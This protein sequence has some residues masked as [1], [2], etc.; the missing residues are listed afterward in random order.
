[1]GIVFTCAV[2]FLHLLVSGRWE[3]VRRLQILPG[4]VV[5]LLIA[6]PWH[7]AAGMA[8][9]GFLWFYFVNEHFLRYLGLRYPKD[10]DTVP[11]ILFWVLH[12]VWV[13]P[14]TAFLWGLWRSFPKMARPTGREDQVNLFLYVWVLT[15]LLFFS[16]S[17]TQ[18][19]YTFPTL[20]A[21]ALLLGRV[22]GR[23]DSP[24]GAADQRKAVMGMSVVAVVGVITAG[25]LFALA[26]MG[27]GGGGTSDLS[28]TLTIN[29]EQYALSF[30]HMHDLT[31]ATFGHL[32]PLV[33]RTAVV[34]LLGPLLALAAGCLRQWK[35]T[36]FFLA[37]MM[38]G[39][40]HSYRCG[41]E[42]FEPIMSSK[43]LAKT[44]EYHYRPGDRL[45]VNGVYERGSSIN[46]YTGIQLSLLN[47]HF[48]NLWYG[49][50][51]PDSPP[52]FFNDE[53]FLGIW[54]SGARV[55]LFSEKQPLADFEARHPGFSGGARTLA[56]DGGKTVLANW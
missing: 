44:I 25:C 46:Y 42:A 43:G 11:V 15:I 24:E 5:F 35:L 38:A 56:R 19:Y 27:K 10:Y 18:E 17:T 37:V 23:L 12:L 3:A 21:F 47:G 8:N 52:I 33:F 26:W 45:V 6:A 49:S 54:N 29:P 39:L 34:I 9:K 13:F 7:I 32:S 1:V 41:M 2:I 36:V 16:F 28:A 53:T 20:P 30:G 50:Y 55:F 4:I 51:F 14:W 40:M 31:P 48:G 22:L